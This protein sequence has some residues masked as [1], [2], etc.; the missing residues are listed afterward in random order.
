MIHDL[1]SYSRLDTLHDIIDSD[2]QALV[3]I[4]RFD[5]S[6]GFGDGSVE[7]VCLENDIHTD[8]FLAVL[9]Y[10]SGK[11]W[12]QYEID[13][14]TLIG[15]LRRSHTSFL[16]YALPGIKKSLIEGIHDNDATEISLVIL[17]FFDSYMN[18]VADHMNYEDSVIFSYVE[19]LVKGNITNRFQISE[20]S[21]SHNHMAGKLTDLTNL[22][23]YKFKQKNNEMINN[24][25]MQLLNCG[26]DLIQHCDIEN[27][28][29]FPQI[30]KLERQV[31]MSNEIEESKEE[32]NDTEDADALSNR[33]KEVLRYI[34]MGLSTKEI[35]D[36]MFLSHHTVNTHRKNI[37]TKLNIHSVTGM[38]VYAI[39]HHIIDISEI[40]LPE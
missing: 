26:K 33:E 15:Y 7:K 29:L 14:M 40:D 8:T 28:M 13:L 22:F 10:L 25:L 37:G 21:S 1:S 19:N 24:A 11:K 6:L 9:N 16:D 3:V 5:I 4:N 38:A 2:N 20:F 23:I 34:A 17:K 27:S 39:L 36:K 12:K 31:R 35:A 32:E 18:E 30:S